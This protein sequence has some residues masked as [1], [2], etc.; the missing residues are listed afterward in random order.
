M[1]SNKEEE[2]K[3]C[4]GSIKYKEVVEWDDPVIALRTPLLRGIYAYGFEK[5]SPIQ[6]NGLHP[7]IAVQKNKQRRDI[8]GQAQSGTRKDR[9]F[10]R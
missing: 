4:S 3:E 10:C 8:I 9:M 1:M 2:P 5:T 6:K 7:M